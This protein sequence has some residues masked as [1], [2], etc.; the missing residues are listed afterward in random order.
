MTKLQEIN[1][2]AKKIRKDG[3]EWKS[4]VKRAAAQLKK[5]D[6]SNSS[7]KSSESKST[8]KSKA[9]IPG[10]DKHKKQ[11]SR[12][13]VKHT[14]PEMA[15][16]SI[17]QGTSVGGKLV[18]KDAVLVRKRAVMTVDYAESINAQ[19]HLNG[20]FCEMDEAETKK[21]KEHKRSEE[22]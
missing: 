10:A 12:K 15:V 13:A 3:E 2:L 9:K 5:G 1:A 19:S 6:N 17:L 4:A 18:K 16:Y 7:K 11:G 22:D 8:K 14:K 20:K 21:L